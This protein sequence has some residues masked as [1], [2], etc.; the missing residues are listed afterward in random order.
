[1]HYPWCGPSIS[2]N[3]N[4]CSTTQTIP[5]GQCISVT[6]CSLDN[7]GEV[8]VNPT[9]AAGYVSGECDCKNNWSLVKSSSAACR[10][11]ARG[12]ADGI[13]PALVTKCHANTPSTESQTGTNV[14]ISHVY[15]DNKNNTTDT[16]VAFTYLSN[17]IAGCAS[18]PLGWYY[19]SDK[20]K[21]MLCTG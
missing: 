16:P 5:P 19:N 17:G 10:N 21:F 7:N 3:D 8:I 13:H 18:T 1:D 12:Q 14:T 15:N 6:G 2:N 4:H 9:S 11:A 20:S